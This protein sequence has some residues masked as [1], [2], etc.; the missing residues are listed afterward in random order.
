MYYLLM[1]TLIRPQATLTIATSRGHLYKNKFN[2]NYADSKVN[3]VK[4]FLLPAILS[5]FL[6][7]LV[8]ETPQNH[9]DICIKNYSEQV[10]DIF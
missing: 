5:S 2:S 9:S 10:C 4:L 3:K 6:F 7:L 1:K 8:P